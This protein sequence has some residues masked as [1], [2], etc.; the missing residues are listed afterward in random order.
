MCNKL[1]L[2]D[3]SDFSIHNQA[4][5]IEASV[6]SEANTWMLTCCQLE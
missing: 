4:S 2:S 3:W 5:S 1:L 6:K